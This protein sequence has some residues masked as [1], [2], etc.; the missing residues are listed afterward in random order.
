MS[1]PK[2][3]KDTPPTLTGIDGR[4]SPDT[5]FRYAWVQHFSG[6]NLP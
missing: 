5:D 6:S 2:L 3:T 4:L 1:A